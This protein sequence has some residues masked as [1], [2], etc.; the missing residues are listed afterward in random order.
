MGTC[1]DLCLI[2]V[3]KTKKSGMCGSWGE[4]AL[5]CMI[6]SSN[7]AITVFLANAMLIPSDGGRM[8]STTVDEEATITGGVNATGSGE[9]TFAGIGEIFTTSKEDIRI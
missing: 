5:S 6:S 2:K 8:V 4:T 1:K 9:V 3:P 7:K